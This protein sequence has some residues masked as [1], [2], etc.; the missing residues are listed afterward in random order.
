MDARFPAG[1]GSAGGK[2]RAGWTRASVTKQEK[3][4]QD[5]RSDK[6]SD[7]KS[8]RQ[9]DRKSHCRSSER[10]ERAS[11]ERSERASRLIEGTRQTDEREIVD[12]NVQDYVCYFNMV[13]QPVLGEGE[14]KPDVGSRRSWV[15]A[16]GR[17]QEREARGEAARCLRAHWGLHLPEEDH[18]RPAGET[19]AEDWHEGGGCI[20]PMWRQQSATDSLKRDLWA[21]TIHGAAVRSSLSRESEEAVR[22][23]DQNHA[24][25]AEVAVVEVAVVDVTE[26]A[27]RE[28]PEEPEDAKKAWDVEGHEEPAEEDLARSAAWDLGATQAPRE[29]PAEPEDATRAWADDG[30]EEPAEED[31]ARS[32]AW[33]LGEA[34]A[35]EV[36]ALER[37]EAANDLEEIARAAVCHAGSN[38]EALRAPGVTK[39]CTSS[40][41]SETPLDAAAPPGRQTSPVLP[42]AAASLTSLGLDTLTFL[43]AGTVLVLEASPDSR[44]EVRDRD[45][46]R[47]DE[48]AKD[49]ADRE[50]GRTKRFQSNPFCGVKCGNTMK[51]LPFGPTCNPTLAGCSGGLAHSTET[52]ARPRDPCSRDDASGRP[53]TQSSTS[54]DS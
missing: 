38:R 2:P 5:S 4:Q 1:G 33:D 51:P 40:R 46:A 10:S 14:T 23:E 50:K 28:H 45:S 34:A 17:A 43:Q 49:E 52:T 7:C 21:T 29:H 47:D 36:C 30:P 15:G 35:R 6:R 3:Q 18:G 12:T 27:P 16:T 31:L 48:T 8:D 26:Q 54:R 25:E 11:N 19:A 32:A 42:V 39:T 24:A 41:R 44:S 22:D 53:A 9:S 37:L 13:A 20:S